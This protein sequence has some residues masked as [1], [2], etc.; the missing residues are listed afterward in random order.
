MLGCILNDI[1]QKKRLL[2]DPE[3]D[4]L[5]ML[6]IAFEY[7]FSSKATFYAVFKQFVGKTPNT[8]KQ[9]V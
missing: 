8:Y 5:N 4:N 7:G 9:M 1:K 2:K 6:G 3:Y